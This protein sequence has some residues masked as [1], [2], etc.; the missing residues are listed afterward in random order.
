MQNYDLDILQSEHL[1]KKKKRKKVPSTKINA[2]P[3]Q[4]PDIQKKKKCSHF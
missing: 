3:S 4:Y 2:H 1:S